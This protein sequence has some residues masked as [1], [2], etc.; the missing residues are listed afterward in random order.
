MCRFLAYKGREIFMSDLLMRSEQ[1]L[2]RQSFKAREREEPLNGDGFGVGWYD[3]EVDS[4]P[5]VFTSVQPAWANRNLHRLS[6]KIRSTCFFAHVRAASSGSP[7]SELNCH[8]F[9]YKR[10]LWMHNGRIASFERIKR[11]LRDHL[12]DEYYN[13]IQGT[14]DSEHAF[15]VFLDELH[16]QLGK[17]TLDTLER[18][19][20]ETIV[21]IRHWQKEAGIDEGSHLNFSVT[22]GNNL[23]AARYATDPV[24]QPQTLYISKGE[25]FELRDNH[26]RMINEGEEVAAVI[27]ASEPLTDDRADWQSIPANHLVSVSS[28]FDV[29]IRPL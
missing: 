27:I 25:R 4:S 24:S 13:Y 20:N 19:L 6:E 16:P 26:Y 18:T 12:S 23:L 17:Y 8:P 14:T 10:F 1:S 15:A 29:T 22:D 2:I 21:K 9:Q 7:V 5:C 3:Q 28:D 11:R